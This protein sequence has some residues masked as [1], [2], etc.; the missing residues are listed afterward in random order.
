M[1]G[2]KA[3][4]PSNPIVQPHGRQ[5]QY[6]PPDLRVPAF[7]I[8]LPAVALSAIAQSFLRHVPDSEQRAKLADDLALMMSEQ[9]AVAFRSIAGLPPKVSS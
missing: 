2:P 1:T 6:P 7:Q 4:F 8:R 9:E 5:T 3:G